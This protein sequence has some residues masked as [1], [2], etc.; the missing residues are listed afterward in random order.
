MVKHKDGVE[1]FEVEV[2]ITIPLTVR[3]LVKGTVA[4]SKQEALE[5]AKT[6][7]NQRLLIILENQLRKDL[8]NVEVD[9]TVYELLNLTLEAAKQGVVKAPTIE[10]VYE[11]DT[12]NYMIEESPKKS[13]KEN[14]EKEI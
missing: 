14:D 2:P 6:I 3:I 1:T 8:D 13:L 10:D 5:L 9:S 11:Q 7:P 4:C 12:V